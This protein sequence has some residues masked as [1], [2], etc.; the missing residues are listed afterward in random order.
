MKKLQLT[1]LIACFLVAA[2]V[3]VLKP[4]GADA[5]WKQDSNGWWN[6]EGHSCSKGWKSLDGKW[7]YFGQDGY[8]VHDTTIDGYII[9]ADGVWIQSAENG[10]FTFDK[11]VSLMKTKVNNLKVEDAEENFLPATR[12]IINIG[13]EELY[14]YIYDN[15]EK[16]EKDALNID[17][18]GF[19]YCG[20]SA[21]GKTAAA[22]KG[23]WISDPHFYK[24]GNIIV[25]YVGI[26]E[27]I[28]CDL[29]DIFGEQFAGDKEDT[30]T[31]SIAAQDKSNL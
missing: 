11:F 17:G 5:Q 30:S 18:S 12:K 7:Y 1:K 4:M 24:K 9:G 15:N 19:V 20:T 22:T 26:N 6:N 27:E 28:I 23:G 8:M 10:N 16:M 3:F 21:D 2:S 29:K 25:Q 13:D 31:N 14:V